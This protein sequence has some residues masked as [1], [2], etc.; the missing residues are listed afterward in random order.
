M[1]EK[2]QKLRTEIV[3]NFRIFEIKK[4]TSL[5]PRTG[6]KHAFYVLD[7]ADWV[8]VIPITPEGK[9]VLI[10]QFRH[11]TEEITLEIPGGVVD[12]SDANPKE[13]A[14]RELI[15]ETGF[16]SDQIVQIGCVTSNPAILNNRCYTF[17][18]NNVRQT[19]KQAFDSSED[20]AVELYDL[21]DVHEMIRTGR[22]H[23]ALV[24]AAFYYLEQF[25]QH[26]S[27]GSDR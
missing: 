1:I 6:E 19:E 18:A 3:G 26:D 27:G 16:D 7:T 25:R 5:S 4:N 17:L 13:C 14:R 22:I 15:E 8:N 24:V 23:H 10:H 9:V 21:K 2:W 11:G 12:E 20:I